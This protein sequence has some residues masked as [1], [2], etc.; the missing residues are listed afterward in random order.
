V[1]ERFINMTIRRPSYATNIE[2]NDSSPIYI[3]TTVISEKE[4]ML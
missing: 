3:G 4:I 1:Y 2:I